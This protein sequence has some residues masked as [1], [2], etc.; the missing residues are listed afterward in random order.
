MR[1]G[2]LFL[3]GDVSFFGLEKISQ[4][5]FSLRDW[6]VFISYESVL[7]MSLELRRISGWYLL[8]KIIMD[9]VFSWKKK[10]NAGTMSSR[11]SLYTWWVK[12]VIKTKF[13]RSDSLKSFFQVEVMLMT[14][15]YSNKKIAFA[16][17]VHNPDLFTWEGS[18]TLW[19]SLV[20]I[21]NRDFILVNNW[22]HCFMRRIS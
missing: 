5:L 20:Q 18:P 10:R 3:E 8:K 11:F 16:R 13:E 4:A 7:G 12:I 9:W 21:I 1:L 2:I 6:S 22:K 14:N 17:R 15:S 19:Q